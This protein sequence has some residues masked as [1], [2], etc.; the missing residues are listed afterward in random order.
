V[1]GALVRR[2]GDLDLAEDCLQ[3]AAA[4]AWQRWP[5]DGVPDAPGAWLL[6]VARNRALDTLRREARR[7]GLEMRAAGVVPGDPE[8]AVPDVADLAVADAAPAAAAAPDAGPASPLGDDVLPLLLMCCHP[9]LAPDTQVALTLRAVAGLTTPEIARAYLV[10][11]ATIAQ[12]LV[13][14]KRKIAATRIPFRL[15]EGEELRDRVNSVLQVVYLVFNEGYASS[16]DGGPVRPE[17]CAEAERLARLVHRLVPGDAEAGGLLALVLLHGSRLAARTDATGALVPLERQDRSLWDGER[18]RE[19]IRLV[20]H[21]LASGPLGPYQL[22]S[23]IAALHAEAATPEATDWPQIAALY[24]LLE[25]VAPGP[26]VRL[27]LAV[28]VAMAEGP[29]A[30]LA[31]VD[32]LAASGELAGHHRLEAV[33]GHLLERLGRDQDAV[34]AFRAAAAAA[35]AATG[36]PAEAAYLARRADD[37]EAKS[38]T[39][40]RS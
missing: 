39:P 21:V 36:S 25:E 29:D 19:G 24:R 23:A 10:P 18:I 9:A 34:V 17:L 40:P 22:Q 33:R 30:G 6:T 20:E 11:E 14:A 3:E 2:F 12:R 8:P 16:G 5:R 37:L 28:A 4:T 26:M 38:P 31:L 7:P 1:L 35:G 15:P 27:N 13:R 32:E